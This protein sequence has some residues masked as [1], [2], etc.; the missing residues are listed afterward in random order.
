MEEAVALCTRVGV[1]VKG[2]LLCLGTVQYLKTKYLDGYTIDIQCESG[3]TESEIDEVVSKVA[4]NALPGS[5]ISE[6]HGRFLRFDMPSLS[7]LGLGETF[8]RLQQ[9]REESSVDNYSISQCSLEQVFIKL[10]KGDGGSN[11]QRPSSADG[12]ESTAA[13]STDVSE[14][15]VEANK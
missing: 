13:A 11:L 14:F 8:R 9:L 7:S 2:Q 1:M 4:T 10:V 12:G 15:D 5:E 3:A 6:R